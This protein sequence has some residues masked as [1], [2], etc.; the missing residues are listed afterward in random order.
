MRSALLAVLTGGLLSSC[1]P[2]PV[3]R[4]A[5]PILHLAEI[6]PAHATTGPIAEGIGR[7][8]VPLDARAWTAL[9][10][11]EIVGAGDSR[12]A[13]DADRVDGDRG[14]APT[15]GAALEARS[16]SGDLLLVGPAVAVEAD[17]WE[18][19]LIEYRVEGA[20]GAELYWRASDEAQP[21]PK[22]RVPLDGGAPGEWQTRRIP[23]SQLKRWRGTIAQFA[24]RAPAAPGG[25]AGLALRALEVRDRSALFAGSAMGR[26]RYEIG[27]DSRPVVFA[28]APATLEYEVAFPERARVRC[29]AAILAARAGALTSA[30]LRAEILDTRGRVVAARDVPADSAARWAEI[31]LDVPEGLVRGR[32]RLTADAPPGAIALWAD[33]VVFTRDLDAKPDLVIYLIDCLRPDRVGHCGY[34]RGGTPEIDRFARDATTFANAYS[35]CTWTRPSLASI[36]TSVYP[37]GHA[38]RKIGDR[39]SGS[40]PTLAECLAAAGYETVAFTSNPNSGPAA[41]LERGFERM[42]THGTSRDHDKYGVDLAYLRDWLGSGRD[43]DR[44][45]FVFIHTI[46]CHG[47]YAPPEPYASL[48]APAGAPPSLPPEVLY[49]PLR[50]KPGA[51]ARDLAFLAAR[52]DGTVRLADR[53][54]GGSLALLEEA[55]IGDDAFVVLISDHGESLGEHGEFGHDGPPY[56]EQ[57]R[58]PC[59]V[60]LPRS[61]RGDAAASAASAASNSLGMPAAARVVGS[62]VQLVDLMPTAL[63]LLEIG[64]PAA[65]GASLRALLGGTGVG[66]AA[67]EIVV[68]RAVGEVAA[69]E[70]AA[71]RAP[72]RAVFSEQ[73]SRPAVAVIEGMRKLVV[74]PGDSA[75]A[76]L[77][78]LDADPGERESR[79]SE[80]ARLAA[81]L[82]AWAR[83]QESIRA[84]HA[85]AAAGDTGRRETAEIDAEVEERLRA[86]GYIR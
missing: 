19:L 77:T 52:W 69:G 85:G 75:G 72:E 74:R 48:F 55:G 14:D 71:V 61:A 30:R 83:E 39:L 4:E 67:G 53:N 58:V 3:P 29:S 47:P 66:P 11:G 62:P 23:R 34:P 50:P 45:A 81:L 2:R 1:G 17:R 9:P 8:A 12:G 64:G 18:E 41:S 6:E 5:A 80:D 78:L 73:T 33:P 13:R 82:D 38:V 15:D 24:L 44:P 76:L 86:L 84:R 27:G 70:A 25:G 65:S 28:H 21:N 36:M 57:I 51:G 49:D 56:E 46:E 43:P 54:F 42:Y 79:R 40:F 63:D 16:S 59:L 26:E 60:R 7:L 35:N 68:G 10:P 32:V 37:S 22:T 31:A 20:G